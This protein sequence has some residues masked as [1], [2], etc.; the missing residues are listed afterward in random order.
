MSVGVGSGCIL[1]GNVPNADELASMGLTSA[2]R[3][4]GAGVPDGVGRDSAGS[5][6]RDSS[7][8]PSSFPLKLVRLEPGSEGKLRMPFIESPYL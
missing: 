6:A 3:S 8:S 2:I 1:T 4:D 5:T 7:T